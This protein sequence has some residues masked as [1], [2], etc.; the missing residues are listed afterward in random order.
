MLQAC[1]S[2]GEYGY[3]CRPVY[4]HADAKNHSVTNICVTKAGHTTQKLSGSSVGS[5][6]HFYNWVTHMHKCTSFLFI[7]LPL[8][9]VPLE[10]VSFKITLP[11]SSRTSTQW[12]LDTSLELVIHKPQS[13]RGE[14]LYTQKTSSEDSNKTAL[15]TMQK[16]YN[17][18]PS[19]LSCNISELRGTVWVTQGLRDFLQDFYDS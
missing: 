18:I 13:V 7:L 5:T 2:H 3:C 8:I 17:R 4:Q 15:C 16:K 11:L 1:C 14:K 6:Y 10:L 12:L 19:F 9:N